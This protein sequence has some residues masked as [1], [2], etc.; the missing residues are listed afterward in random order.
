VDP[1]VQLREAPHVPQDAFGQIARATDRRANAI[2]TVL[3]IHMGVGEPQSPAADV[4]TTALRPQH[5]A[6]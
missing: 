2:S 6:Q 1:P 4:T 3:V 5:P